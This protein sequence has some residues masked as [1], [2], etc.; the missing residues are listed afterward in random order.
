[1]DKRR[2]VRR[3]GLSAG[4]SNPAPGLFVI[5]TIPLQLGD[6]IIHP[7][8]PAQQIPRSGGTSFH[9]GSA[10]QTHLARAVHLRHLTQTPGLVLG[11][12]RYA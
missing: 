2:V 7:D 11:T 10:M 6:Q 3:D 12:D 1:M 8:S 4:K 5:R 9:A